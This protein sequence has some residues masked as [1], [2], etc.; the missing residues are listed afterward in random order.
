MDQQIRYKPLQPASPSIA[1][2]ASRLR[3]APALALST[4]RHRSNRWLVL[5]GAGKLLKAVLFVA[6]GFGALH[7]VHKDLVSVVYQWT[8]D[9]RFDPE[10][11]FVNYILDKVSL[12][13]P[14]RLRLISVGIFVYA[15]VDTLEGMGLILGKT[16]AEYL[17]LILTAS[18][19]PWE[20]FEL[21]HRPNWPKLIFALL[22][23]AVVWY[24]AAYLRRRHQERRA[25]NAELQS[26]QMHVS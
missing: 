21:A 3:Q 18:L 10:S 25:E 26:E 6:L 16:W 9:L 7:L 4:A 24:L 15:A 23:I 5:I 17:T 12:I 20:F 1:P 19:L 14:H 11:H 8:L 13:S 22:N 2:S